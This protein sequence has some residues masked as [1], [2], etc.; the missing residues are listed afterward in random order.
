[1]VDAVLGAAQGQDHGGGGQRLAQLAVVGAALLG[2]VA[3]AL[4]VLMC[5]RCVACQ[6]CV[7]AIAANRQR[8]SKFIE[9]QFKSFSGY[10]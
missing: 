1:M 7:A 5:I 10:K 3:A 6:W 8:V 2:A 9:S 4:W